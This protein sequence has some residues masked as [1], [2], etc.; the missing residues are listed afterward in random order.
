VLISEFQRLLGFQLNPAGCA[1]FLDMTNWWVRPTRSQSCWQRP[2]GP[3]GKN[4]G[5][6]SWSTPGQGRAQAGRW[7]GVR[8][9]RTWEEGRSGEV[10]ARGV[11][12]GRKA[13]VLGVES[14]GNESCEVFSF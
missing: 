14:T 2:R 3:E 11:D 13:C 6:R 8:A 5:A 4:T 1:F 7:Q 10:E 9:R 12:L